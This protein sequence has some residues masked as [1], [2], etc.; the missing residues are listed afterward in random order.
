MQEAALKSLR[1]VIKVF[2][3]LAAFSSSAVEHKCCENKYFIHQ[4]K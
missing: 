4:K 3:S 2:A 1:L